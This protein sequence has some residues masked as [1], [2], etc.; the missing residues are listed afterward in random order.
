MSSEE[1]T[2]LSIAIEQA[3]ECGNDE[4]AYFLKDG[5]EDSWQNIILKR[6]EYL[7][8]PKHNCYQRYRFERTTTP[9]KMI[10]EHFKIVHYCLEREYHSKYENFCYRTLQELSC[11]EAN[12]RTKTISGI[13]K[14][15]I[16]IHNL[17]KHLGIPLI[18]VATLLKIGT[19]TVGELSY[20]GKRICTIC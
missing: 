12:R 2:G 14:R 8:C 7:E 16:V 4:I 19:S 13:R 15:E 9:F 11:F 17:M 1:T 6:L 18:D 3:I 5:K 10:F 20:Q